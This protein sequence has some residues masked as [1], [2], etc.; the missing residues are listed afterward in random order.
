MRPLPGDNDP[1]PGERL[2]NFVE[3]VVGDVEIACDLTEMLRR[4][5]G[6]SGQIEHRLKG[7]FT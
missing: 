4:T 2:Q 6:L 1:I 5:F 3:E 7:V